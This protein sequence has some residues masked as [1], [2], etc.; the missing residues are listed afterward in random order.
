MACMYLRPVYRWIGT[1]QYATARR[2]ALCCDSIHTIHGQGG[3]TRFSYE[4]GKGFYVQTK[5]SQFSVGIMKS[6]SCLFPHVPAEC[7]T[8]VTADMHGTLAA[9]RSTTQDMAS[10]WQTYIASCVFN[11]VYQNNMAGVREFSRPQVRSFF[12]TILEDCL[13]PTHGVVL[14]KCLCQVKLNL[15]KIVPRL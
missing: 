10:R 2:L 7:Q 6:C 5:N 14:K 8:A 1:S 4:T 3:A 13:T 12:N 11:L 15:R 9:N